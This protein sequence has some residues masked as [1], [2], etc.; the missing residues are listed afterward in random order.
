MQA[1]RRPGDI[2]LPRDGQ[3][4]SKNANIHRLHP[5]MSIARFIILFNYDKS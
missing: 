2:L 5:E 1:F 3:I 4:I